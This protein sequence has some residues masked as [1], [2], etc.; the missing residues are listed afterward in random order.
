[1][2][3]HIFLFLLFVFASPLCSPL[4]PGKIGD[5]TVNQSTSSISLNWTAPSGQVFVY[6]VVWNNNGSLMCTYT[7]VTFAGL[8]GLMAGTPYTITVTGVAGDNQTEGDPYTLISFT[9]KSRSLHPASN[10]K[11]D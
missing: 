4:G 7:N 6:K 10:L 2:Y 1:M 11:N 9:S 8:S 5:P 3:F